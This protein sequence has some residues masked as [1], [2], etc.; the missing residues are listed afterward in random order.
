MS[1]FTLREKIK[2][3]IYKLSDKKLE[4]VDEIISGLLQGEKI[5]SEKLQGM[6]EGLGFEKISDL[7]AQIK[8]IR[9]A[10]ENHLNDRT[11]NWNI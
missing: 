11:K 3:N 8:N 2:L 4:E 6:W 9:I 10:S 1:I 5:K 7:D